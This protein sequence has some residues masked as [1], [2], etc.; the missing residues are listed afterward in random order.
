MSK[1]VLELLQQVVSGWYF[2]WLFWEQSI[3]PSDLGC[4]SCVPPIV[5][6]PLM[7]LQAVLPNL[8]WC[9][10]IF[11]QMWQVMPR[12]GS[13][14]STLWLGGVLTGR[15]KPQTDSSAASTHFSS[16]SKVYAL[17]SCTMVRCSSTWPSRA[18]FTW[19]CI[20]WSIICAPSYLP[21]Q[22]LVLCCWSH[23]YTCTLGLED[24][25]GKY[26]SRYFSILSRYSI[27]ISI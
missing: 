6:L 3:L 24:M 7:S 22:W 13:K 8:G 26:S 1:L 11:Q 16:S 9:S 27:Y 12:A 17:A 21:V 5:R 10:Y 15:L 18:W 19:E 2:S 25:C 23:R 20:C 14:P 4:V